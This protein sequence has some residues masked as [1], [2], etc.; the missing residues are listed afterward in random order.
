L[1][2][3]QDTTVQPKENQKR[4]KPSVISYAAVTSSASLGQ[5]IGT[6][7][8]GTPSLVTTT[9]NLTQQVTNVSSLTDNDIDQLYDR[10]KHHIG[11]ADDSSPGITTEDMERMVN[12]S[13]NNLQ[14]VCEEMRTSVED[15]KVEVASISAQVKKQNA[16]VVGVQKPL[17]TTSKDLKDSV[18]KQ[19]ADL[20]SQVRDIRSLVMALLPPLALQA[21]TQPGGAVY[22]MSP[23][24]TSAVAQGCASIPGK[25]QLSI[26]QYMSTSIHVTNLPSAASSSGTSKTPE[27]YNPDKG[28]SSITKIHIIIL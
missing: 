5:D 10:L 6:V 26:I 7:M 2:N 11:I 1:Y 21:E 4:F 13:N 25:K 16:V 19:V 24:K 3:P 22:Q 20:S 8:T 23:N 14:Q 9:Q 12:E 28:I 17:E 27:K 18:N 15:L